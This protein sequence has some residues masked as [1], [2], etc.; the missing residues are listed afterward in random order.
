MPRAD[1]ILVWAGLRVPN[2]GRLPDDGQ[3]TTTCVACGETQTLAQA[4]IEQG[5]ETVYVCKNG[6]QPILV[7]GRPG[8][9]AW[10][11]R[12]YR[13]G[14]WVL[15]NPADLLVPV[16]DRH[17]V[18]MPSVLN[19]PASPNALADESERPPASG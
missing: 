19:I 13:L 14:D 11:G 6:C 3:M 16:F 7:V 4:E 9:V 1:E 18:P 10:P 2:G 12:G 8:T 5:D 15:R 17:G